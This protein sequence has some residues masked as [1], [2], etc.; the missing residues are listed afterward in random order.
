MEYWAQVRLKGTDDQ[1]TYEW[2][3]ILLP[4]ELA[5]MFFKFGSADALFDESQ[6]DP[7]SKAHLA[8][9]RA[10]TGLLKMLGGSLHGDGVPCN[11]DKSESVEVISFNL[12]GVGGKWRICWRCICSIAYCISTNRRTISKSNHSKWRSYM[13]LLGTHYPRRCPQTR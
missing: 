12:P 6:L 4:L 10:M 2:V 7:L 8:K 9:C 11:W 13:S 1:E 5:E 3:A